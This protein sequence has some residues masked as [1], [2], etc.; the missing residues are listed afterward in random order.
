MSRAVPNRVV[1][2]ELHTSDAEQA[3]AFYAQ[4]CG[5]R[6]E[7]I[8]T[9]H[10]AYQ[11]VELGTMG[12]G[13]VECPTQ[14]SL[15]LPYVAVDDVHSATDRAREHGAAVLLGPREGPAGWR[16]VIATRAGAELAFWQWK[17]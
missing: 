6:Q 12:G 11:A 13:F 9:R 8:L 4:V 17:A 5:W 10:G 3:R 16:S 14:R 1:H 7:R 2:L 15:W